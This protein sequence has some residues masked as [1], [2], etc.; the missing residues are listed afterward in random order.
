MKLCA[1]CKQ[2][3][4]DAAFHRKADAADGLYPHCMECRKAKDAV[5]RLENI[6]R[7]REYEQRRKHDPARAAYQAAR[8]K[9]A[10][11]ANK[12][13]ALMKMAEYARSNP[14]IVRRAKNAY[15]ARNPGKV[16]AA[17][18]KRQASKINA[19]PAWADQDLIEQ[20]YTLARLLTEHT[21]E[22]YQVDHEVPLRH[23]LVQG[24]HTESNLRVIPALQN[25]QKGNRSWADMP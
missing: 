25:Q 3:K 8:L 4:P 24:L 21:G 17:V 15:K 1:T 16:M 9:A 20:T 14:E 13:A 18:R 23:P 10:Y 12:P 7:A 2:E 19:T 6:E 22:Q 5:Y 11:E